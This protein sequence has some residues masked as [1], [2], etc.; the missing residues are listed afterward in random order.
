MAVRGADG[1][2]EGYD[3]R[4]ERAV[5]AVR[6]VPDTA[7]WLVAK[8]DTEEAFG[9]L[10]VR[11]GWT[12]AAVIAL[13]LGV[14]GVIGFG[15]QRREKIHY[16]DLART[17]HRHSTLLHSIGDGVIATDE[18][19]RIELMNPVAEA[20]TGWQQS[21]ARGRPLDDVFSII[22]EDT[23][24]P[25]ESPVAKVLRR[26]AVVGLANST[27]LIAKDGTERPIADSGAPVHED[28]GRIGGVVLVFRDRTEQRKA[29]RRLE[30][31]LERAQRYLDVAGVMI[32]VLG[33]EGRVELINRRGG[34]ILGYP[35]DEIVGKDWF[36]FIPEDQRDEVREVFGLAIAGDETF[37]EEFE[38]EVLTRGGEERIIRWR[39]AVVQDGNGAITRT[40]S[41]GLDVTERRRA[42]EA[43][44]RNEA[45]YRNLFNSIRDAIL[46]TNTDREIIGCNPAFTDLF[47]YEEEEILGKQT[48]EVYESR[49]EFEAMGRELREHIGDPN[50]IQT[51]RYRKKSGEVFPGETNAF[52]LRDAA[53]E[54]VGFIGL[55]RDVTRRLQAQQAL[56]ESEERYRTLYEAAPIGIF[57][58][59]SD[60]E[61][62]AVNQAM[63]EILGFDRP[64]DAVHHYHD[65][66]EQ[67]YVRPERRDEFLR[68]LREQGHVEDFEYEAR[69]PDGETAW[70]EMH[71]RVA[72]RDDDG[73]FHI[74]GFAIDVTEERRREEELRQKQTMLERTEQLA[75]M[76]SW[77]LDVETGEVTWSD[78][79]FRVFGRDPSEGAPSLGENED[80]FPPEDLARMQ[81]AVTAAIEH[82]QPYDLEVR[83][84]RSDGEIRTCRALGYPERGA[85]GRVVHLYGTFNDITERKER[86]EREAE[87]QAQL[88]QA[89]K[90]ESIGR[91]AGGV[92]HD[93][94][95]MLS[96]ILGHV[97]IAQ[98]RLDP[99]E[100]LY[101]DLEAVRKAA[102]SSADLTRQL[103]A[104]AREQ[105]AT[106]EVLELNQ[107][108]GSMLKMLGRLIGENIELRWRPTDEGWPVRVDPVQIDQVLTNLLV[109]ARDAIDGVGEVAIETAA[110][111]VDQ[112]YAEVHPDAHPGDYMV[113]SIT[114]SGP[115]MEPAVAERAFDPFFTTKDPGE[116]TGLGL[117][118]VYGIV[119]QNNG[120]IHLYTEPGQGTTFKVYF[121]RCE[122]EAAKPRETGAPRDTVGA[123]TVLV[124][125]DQA[126]VLEL[127]EKILSGLGYTVLTAGTPGEA[128]DI[129]GE[130]SDPIHLLISDVVMPE[131]NGQELAEKLAETVGDIPVLFMSGYAEDVIAERGVIEDGVHFIEKPFTRSDLSTQV[132][133]ALDDD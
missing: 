104:F 2:V 37:P 112:E 8:V 110:V 60:G 63:A 119:H 22:N 81:D 132:R 21:E 44:R 105:V 56:E 19:G 83:A 15:W 32:V 82:G 76:G 43:V 42:E 36:R 117:A 115:G 20:L 99:E 23:R 133:K 95:N 116:G 75:T 66:G 89:Q 7:W 90:M 80:L 51:I 124:V 94:N 35:E 26:G 34:E 79:L 16:R 13:L 41:S 86:E 24:E 85:D 33:P 77:E 54:V 58:T 55:I 69:R 14:A 46:V 9:P 123:E 98:E 93:F 3:Y 126:A 84:I 129:A 68:I 120:F 61:A 127:V 111:S 30:H 64:E 27:V 96:V 5:A 49:E 40:I 74:E 114:D 91:L 6:K 28:D 97:E 38:N 121:P 92:A 71:A 108:I 78:E 118:T 102:E 109:N 87:L 122:E 130:R 18:R 10:R 128:I 45:R 125:E 12:V 65:L 4:D 17:E 1:V 70:L 113:L 52:Y 50:F 53:D 67:L 59:R 25:V 48:A 73:T 31:A 11:L 29:Q 106:P 72:A 88:G 131:M 107:T 101:Q 62:L 39:N 100:S 103:L 47:G 57:R